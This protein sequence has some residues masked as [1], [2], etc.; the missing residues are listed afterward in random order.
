MTISTGVGGGL[1]LD[2]R[3]YRGA[4]GLGGELGHMIIVPDGPGCPCGNHGCWEAVASG[5]AI[6]RLARQRIEGGAGAD[7]LAAAGGRIEMIT[8]E[9]VGEAAVSGSA[10]AR[11][12][13]EEA[14][15]E[16]L[17]DRVVSQ[18][19]DVKGVVGKVALGEADA[20]FVYATDAR[21]AGDDVRAIELPARMQADVRYLVAVV[22]GS[23]QADEARA[24]VD[25]LL[26]DRG[27]RLL[28]EAG[29]GV[30]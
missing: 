14:G 30:P 20:G 13:L 6:G 27:R 16:D 17:L 18:E 8:G 23:D 15:R 28:R 12:V 25:L 24:F 19:E 29:F 4:F 22:T 9:L 7:L 10:F 3:V 26:R 21:A 2:G 1:V 5:R 11:D